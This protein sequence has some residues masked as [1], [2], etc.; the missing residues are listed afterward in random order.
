M[1]DFGSRQGLTNFETGGIGWKSGAC[2]H[3]ASRNKRLTPVR[4]QKP[5]RRFKLNQR[6]FRSLNA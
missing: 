3:F 4:I 5:E 2:A 1:V 6:S